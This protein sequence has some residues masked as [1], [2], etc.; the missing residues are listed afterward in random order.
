MEL[1]DYLAALPEQRRL[2]LLELITD[3]KQLYPDAHLSLVAPFALKAAPERTK[4]NLETS[5][6]SSRL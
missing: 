4:S 3:I 2:G 6:P 5:I 1:S